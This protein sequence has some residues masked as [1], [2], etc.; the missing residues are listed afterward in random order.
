MADPTRFKSQLNYQGPRFDSTEARAYQSLSDKLARWGDKALDISTDLAVTDATQE[1]LRAGTGTVKGLT[2]KQ[3]RTIR[4][5]AYNK[6]ALASHLAAVQTDIRT[7]VG[8]MELEHG[9]DSK[10]FS[11]AL[12]GYSEG[13]LGELDPRV[14]PDAQSAIAEYA[15]RAG[16][17]ILEREQVQQIKVNA[18]EI[19]TAAQGIQIDALNAYRAGEIFD[20]KGK[21]GLALTLQ[22][23][24]FSTWDAGVTTG[25]LDINAVNKAKAS[26]LQDADANMV[27]GEFGRVLQT[28]GIEAAETVLKKFRRIKKSDLPPAARDK[29]VTT[30]ETW[31]TRERTKENRALRKQAAVQAAMVK[32]YKVAVDNAVTVL[33]SG[34]L[35]NGY[36]DLLNAVQGTE[37]SGRLDRAMKIYEEVEK[38][39]AYRPGKQEALLVKLEETP[40]STAFGVELKESYEKVHQTTTKLLKDW[41]IKLGVSLGINPAP[42]PIQLGSPESMALLALRMK[43][44][45]VVESY[46]DI[47][48][49]NPLGPQEISYWSNKLTTL[50]TNQKLIVLNS[51]VSSMGE[52]S[53]PVLEKLGMNN[54]PV[55]AK[56]G[57]LIGHGQGVTARLAVQGLEYLKELKGITPTGMD[58]SIRAEL[59]GVFNSNPKALSAMTNTIKAVYT[60][61]M[62]ES[63]VSDFKNL[64]PDLLE[65]AV[66]K[67]TGGILD[68]DSPGTGWLDDYTIQAPAFGVDADQFQDWIGGLT[69]DDID[70]MGGTDYPHQEAIEMIEDSTLIGV[71]QGRYLIDTGAGFLFNKAGKPFV[72]TWPSARINPDLAMVDPETEMPNIAAPTG[73]PAPVEESGP[74]MLNFGGIET[75]MN[76][77]ENTGTPITEASEALA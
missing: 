16:L 76:V 39:A 68:I 49:L 22:E 69:A 28:G 48:N 15:S 40:P 56:A 70:G 47:K 54:Q 63:G 13:L 75:V 1:G 30:M 74:M 61:M 33:K 60:S 43:Q 34:T 35:P 14:R 50:G 3:D 57:E 53:I 19:A 5:K 26:F 77:P 45:R 21:P 17:R 66:G 24:L 44:V 27:L 25:V 9:R 59:K 12:K 37:L 8:R 62:A 20:E 18:A 32:Q 7:N 52:N 73:L 2:L 64:D 71:G 23:K 46:Y 67:V 55:L 11:S 29:L 58:D 10:G 38:F 31:I 6:A 41:P 65:E 72:L 42:H 51:M 36:E 4:G